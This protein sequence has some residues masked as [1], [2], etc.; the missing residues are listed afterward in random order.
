MMEGYNGARDRVTGGGEQEEVEHA[1]TG[2]GQRI[3]AIADVIAD[4]E[5]LY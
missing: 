1:G 2:W 5:G 4:E 3:I